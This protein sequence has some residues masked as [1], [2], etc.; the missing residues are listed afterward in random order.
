[1]LMAA[2]DQTIVGTAMPRIVSDL[3]GFEHYSAVITAYMIASTAILPIAGKLSDAYG[4]KPFLLCGVLW[5]MAASALCG[6]HRTE[7]RVPRI[8]DAW[9]RAPAKLQRPLPDGADDR[10]PR[11]ATGRRGRLEAP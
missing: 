3:H 7:D 5:F 9:L 10:R 11:P 2:L 8:L 4:R 1:M 6:D